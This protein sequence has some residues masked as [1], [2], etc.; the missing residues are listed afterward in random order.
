MLNGHPVHDMPQALIYGLD[1]GSNFDS[2]FF[3]RGCMKL[4]L[5]A[6]GCGIHATPFTKFRQTIFYNP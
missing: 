6:G 3:P 4:P 1:S 2:Y 5:E